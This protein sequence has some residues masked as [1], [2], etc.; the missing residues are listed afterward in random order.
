MA[1]KPKRLFRGAEIGYWKLLNRFVGE[2]LVPRWLAHCRYCDQTKPV[3]S[4]SL[5]S[6]RS[7]SCGCWRRE[8]LLA[9]LRTHG[10]TK[11]PIHR[12]WTSMRERCNNPECWDYPRYGGRGITVSPRWDDFSTFAT[13]IGPRPSSAHSLDRIDNDRGYEPGNVR[14][15]LLTL[16]ARNKSNNRVLTFAG[17]QQCVSAWSQETG[18]PIRTIRSRLDRS[19]WTVDKA[20]STPVK[21]TKRSWRIDDRQNISEL[22]PACGSQQGIAAYRDRSR[23]RRNASR[24][25]RRKMAARGAPDN[26]RTAMRKPSSHRVLHAGMKIGRL[27][28]SRQVTHGHRASWEVACTCGTIKTILGSNLSQRRVQ[29][30]GCLR[31]ET[32]RMSKTIHGYS[33]TAEYRAWCHMHDRC[34]NPRT[35]S[36]PYYGGRGIKVHPEWKDFTKF[37]AHVGSRPSKGHSIDRIDCDGDYEPGNVRWATAATQSNNRRNVLKRVLPCKR[38]R[39]SN[40]TD[41]SPEASG[42]SAPAV[43]P[44]SDDCQEKSDE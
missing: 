10:R 39:S 12:I 44:S 16:Q 13:D 20:L 33:G 25:S 18:I 24:R 27:T 34:S 29:S 4:S 38:D 31:R 36:Y 2:D 28:L 30:C 11:D 14:W 41:A 35:D 32:T 8:Q 21:P 1:A 17:R 43:A 6:G 23:Q 19:G 7:S 26:S 37:L 9:R 3:S 15:V 5:L 40:G 42:P 22:V